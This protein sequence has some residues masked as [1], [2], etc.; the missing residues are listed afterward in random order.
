MTMSINTR[1]NRLLKIEETVRE[2]KNISL[3]VLY[4]KAVNDW[5]ITERTFWSYLEELKVT[6]VLDFDNS[7][8][9]T[10]RK[11]KV[12]SRKVKIKK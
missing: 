12:L 7:G 9:D 6:D 8:M 1:R 10:L 5:G 3:G 4:S 2:N 11:S